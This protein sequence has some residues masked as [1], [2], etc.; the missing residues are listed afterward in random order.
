MEELRMAGDLMFMDDVLVSWDC[1]S[2]DRTVVTA[3]YVHR[4][5]S[6]IIETEIIHSCDGCGCISVGAILERMRARVRCEAC[7]R[8]ESAGS[9]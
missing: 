8:A 6:R 1:G 2:G 7:Q 5:G 9:E 3:V 4:D